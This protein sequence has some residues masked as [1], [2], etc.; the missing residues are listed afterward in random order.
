MLKSLEN[1][2]FLGNVGQLFQ[3]HQR[4]AEET[5]QYHDPNFLPSRR[6]A[7]EYVRRWDQDD[8]VM[9]TAEELVGASKNGNGEVLG[10]NGS[11]M[12]FGLKFINTEDG[13][14][15]IERDGDKLRSDTEHGYR[16]CVVQQGELTQFISDYPEATA[17]EFYEWLTYQDRNHLGRLLATGAE[18]RIAVPY[19]YVVIVKSMLHPQKN[20]W[21]VEDLSRSIVTPEGIVPWLGERHIRLEVGQSIDLG[22]LVRDVS[23]AVIRGQR[24]QFDEGGYRADGFNRTINPGTNLVEVNLSEN[25][26]SPL[27]QFELKILKTDDQ[28]WFVPDVSGDVDGIGHDGQI[29]LNNTG[30]ELFCV[31]VESGEY[32][33]YQHATRAKNTYSRRILMKVEVKVQPETGRL[34]LRLAEGTEPMKSVATGGPTVMVPAGGGEK[35]GGGGTTGLPATVSIPRSL[36]KDFEHDLIVRREAEKQAR[37]RLLV[38]E[39]TMDSRLGEAED[40]LLSKDTGAFGAPWVIEEKKKKVGGA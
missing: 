28:I 24:I 5:P 15:I 40:K 12:P 13:E 35:K 21:Q 39:R 6:P 17:Q 32:T 25:S 33:F 14:V 7:P 4:Q 1:M 20:H 11:E 31:P 36:V 2:A 37:E 8:M 19:D 18:G 38:A 3:R 27:N 10:P 34:L 23:E 22:L 30:D 26:R 16:I 29:E 9:L